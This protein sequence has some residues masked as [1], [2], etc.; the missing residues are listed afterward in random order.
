MRRLILFIAVFYVIGLGVVD[1]VAFNGRYSRAVWNQANSQVLR[2]Y[3]E[4]KILL[5][6]IGVASTASARP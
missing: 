2:A 6:R 5:D 4:V 3:A 1:S